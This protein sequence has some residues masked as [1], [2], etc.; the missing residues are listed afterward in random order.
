M[1]EKPHFGPGRNELWFRVWVSLAG[2]AFVGVMLA[3]RGMPTGPGL[4][5]AF[6]IPVLL[7]GGTTLWC[8]RKLIKRDHPE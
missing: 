3:V 4:I 1:D 8:G 7:F 2:L 6:G 5:E